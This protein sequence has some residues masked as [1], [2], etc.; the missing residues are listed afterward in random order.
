MI[1][2]GDIPDGMVVRHKCDNPSCTNPDHLELGTRR[3]NVMDKIKRGRGN[4][5]INAKLEHVEMLRRVME[6]A[7]YGLFNILGDYALEDRNAVDAAYS[8][9][10]S[11][12]REMGYIIHDEEKPN[13]HRIPYT[14]Q[15]L[16]DCNNEHNFRSNDP[17]P[18][19][20]LRPSRQEL[21]REILESIGDR[22]LADLV[23]KTSRKMKEAREQNSPKTFKED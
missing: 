9:L 12:L 14:F 20:G 17:Y 1:H 5:R 16:L 10:E 11:C 21:N 18:K 7:V 22:N 4:A 8:C 2:H 6:D 3:Q 13:K 15:F 19:L 23:K